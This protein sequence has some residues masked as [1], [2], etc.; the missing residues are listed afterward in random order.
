MFFFQRIRSS[1]FFTSRSSS[2]SVIQVNVDIKI[3]SKERI[4]FVGGVLYL[5]RSGPLII[6]III[7]I[8]LWGGF[9]EEE[10]NE[11]CKRPSTI[12]FSKNFVY[13]CNAS[14]HVTHYWC[15]NLFIIKKPIVAHGVK[16]DRLSSVRWKDIIHVHFT[17]PV[18]LAA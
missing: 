15:S 12:L 1:L 18:I 4:G 7:I 2:F 13:K 6:V 5:Q 3:K 11:N 14:L 9:G 16:A 17:D 10:C 8:L